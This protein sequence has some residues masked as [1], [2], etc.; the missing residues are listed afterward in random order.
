MVDG[1][2]PE[3]R[4]GWVG[5]RYGLRAVMPIC[6]AWWVISTDGVSCHGSTQNANEI[7]LLRLWWM[8]ARVLI[9]C[10]HSSTPPLRAST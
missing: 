9:P 6:L 1:M 10:P 3:D 5:K 7:Y 2:A 8:I 4:V